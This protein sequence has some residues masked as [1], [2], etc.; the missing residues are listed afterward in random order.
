VSF[1]VGREAELTTLSEWILNDACRLVALLGIGGIG[2]TTLGVKLTQRLQPEFEFVIWRSL[3]NAPPL[4]KLLQQLVPLVSH[5]QDTHPSIERLLQYL[6]TARC[7][8]ILDNLEAI[9][10]P[11]QLGKF[12]PGYDDYGQLLRLVGETAHQSCLLITSRE[13]PTGVASQEGP[14]LP[15]R[16]LVLSGLQTE[17]DGLLAAKGLSGSAA[18]RQALIETYGGNP[19]ALKIAAT[20]IQDL[21]NGDISTFLSQQTV[22]FNGVRQLL[23]Q[24]FNR[25][26]AL[27]QPLMYWLAINREWT[28]VADLHNDIIPPVS[29]QRVLEGLEAL[30]RR[31]LIEQQAG[32]YTQQPV[33]MEY[34]CDRL[35]EGMV[36]ELTTAELNLFI[37]HTLVKTTVAEYVRDS[38]QRLILKPVAD[39]FRRRFAAIA[40]LEQQILRVLTA[41]RRAEPTYSGYG[42]GN[43]INL[44]IDLGLPLTGF[45]FSGLKIWHA[46][47]QQVELHKINFAHADLTHSLFRETFASIYCVAF[48]PDGT[49]LTSGDTQGHVYL[50]QMPTGEVIQTYAGAHGS[51]IQG[52]AFSPNGKLLATASF[53]CKVKVWAISTGRCLHTFTHDNLTCRVAWNPDG[54]RLA[55]V[56]FDQTI[57][58]WDLTTGGCLNVLHGNTPQIASIAWHPHDDLVIA[59]GGDNTILCWNPLSGKRLKTL[60][61]HQDLVW[62]VVVSPDGKTLVS[63]SQGGVLKFWR[64]ATW[65]CYQTVQGNFGAAWWL[66]F[67]PD[68]TSVVGSCQD[69]TLRLWD[70]QTGECL[71]I[72]WGHTDMALT[73]AFSPDGSRLASGSEDQTLKLWDVATGSCLRTFHGH[74]GAIWDVDISSDN[75]QVVSAHQ[76]GSL[77]VWDV[78]TGECLH[79]LHEH[80]SLV[81]SVAWHPHDALVLSASQDNLLKLWDA[82]SGRCQDTF[83]GHLAMILAV[84]WHPDGRRFASSGMDGLVKIWDSTTGKCLQ[85]LNEGMNVWAVAWHPQGELLATG[86]QSGLI[87]LWNPHSKQCLKSLSGHTTTVCS[88]AF[89]PDGQTLVSSS[90]DNTIRLWDLTKDDCSGTLTGHTGWVWSIA[91][92]PDG[93]RLV[94]ASQDGTVRLWDVQTQ[95]CRRVLK[96]HPNGVRSVC[97]SAD[98]TWIVVGSI[99]ETM[100][101]WNPETGECLKSFR[102]K[103]P[104]EGM[105]I[106]EV[107]GLTEAQK[108]N[109][110]SLGAVDTFS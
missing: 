97:W 94:S 78:A 52:M 79:T 89:S 37:T 59:P 54:T 55:S 41:I 100:T 49:L 96:C 33:V 16:S 103:R 1:F 26:S 107:T 4:E 31:S 61:E 53:D 23:D 105:N 8:L 64:I 10:E 14:T 17:A 72:F 46:C 29:Y 50:R 92:H 82:Q 19:L 20:S 109:L 12:L 7:L 6:R 93:Q 58:I 38:Q 48:S 106:T 5:Q 90:H 3:R 42:G 21:F 13:K 68:G 71:K 36:T 15:V 98:G 67:S 2:K 27:E 51:W 88:L 108:V 69:G 35:I 95:T 63:S 81:W 66:A 86:V 62:Q 56:G 99:D 11:Q 18:D 70:G 57:R 110:R 25:L 65:D 73:V 74:S 60:S 87:N 39:A 84:T 22:L 83:G 91:L 104:Y 80:K 24:Q 43:L 101:L 45:D 34:V 77:R 102:A 9:L 28:A 32:C 30:S 40:T 47:L 44:C 75:Q 76:D 85:T